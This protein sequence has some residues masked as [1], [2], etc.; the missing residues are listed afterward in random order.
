MAAGEAAGHEARV[1]EAAEADHDVEAL[2]HE[3]DVA[4]VELERELEGGMGVCEI[5]E[6]PAQVAAA[7]VHRDAH[8][9][10]APQ[11]GLEL[12]HRL[13]GLGEVRQDR[14]HALVQGAPGVGQRDPARGAMQQARTEA[15]LEGAQLLAD[16]GGRQAELRRRG[17]EAP[18]HRD[19]RKRFVFRE[20]VQ[21]HRSN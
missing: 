4:I 20:L 9:Q 8:A 17:C 18:G 21:A 2:G 16:G 7:E 14:R 15:L 1:G 19:T 10:V 3:V 11:L 13:L 5:G 6:R 12:G